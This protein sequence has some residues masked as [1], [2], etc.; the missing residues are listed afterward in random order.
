[1]F[2]TFAHADRPTIALAM[3]EPGL[4]TRVLCLRSEQCLLTYASLDAGE[5]TAPGQL[6]A[7]ELRQTYGVHRL[8][9]ATRV[10][11]LLGAHRER[12]RLAEYNAWFARDHAS[13]IAL[14]FVV[15][16]AAAG[17]VGAFRELPVSG[18]HIHG[19]E[20]QREVLSALDEVT[21]QKLTQVNA[22]VRRQ[23]GSLVGHWVESPRAQY[24]LWNDVCSD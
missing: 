15:D 21:P 11:G 9:P 17:I 1:V 6:T 24:E 2:R 16:R 5:G 14:P 13:G 3:G 10:Y 7:A 23:D 18:W 20:L 22:V 8:G 4:L 19:P 12:Q